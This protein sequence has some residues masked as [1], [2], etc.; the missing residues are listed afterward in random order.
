[1]T[2]TAMLNAVEY[3][4]KR[5]RFLVELTVLQIELTIEKMIYNISGEQIPD[6]LEDRLF[7]IQGMMKGINDLMGG[8][9]NKK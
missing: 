3:F 7:Q 8:G 1:M 4:S 9:I 2:T 5:V 6:E